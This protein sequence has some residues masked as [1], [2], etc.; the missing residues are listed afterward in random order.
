VVPV[1]P[2]IFCGIMS[3]KVTLKG[4]A[5]SVITGV[6][7]STIFVIDQFIGPEAGSEIF[8][9]LHHKLTLNFG[10][11]G[12]WAIIISIIVLFTVSAFTPKTSPDKLEK[13][14]MNYSKKLEP[15]RGLSDWRLQLLVLTIITILILVWLK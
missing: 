4:A 10:Y 12:L 7:L 13:T 11:R 3:R 1:F 9:F 14:T 15:F 5:A 2:A 8:P 6:I